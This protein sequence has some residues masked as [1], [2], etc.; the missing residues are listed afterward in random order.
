[1]QSQ[2]DTVVQYLAGLPADRRD[3]ID[4]GRGVT[5]EY[6]A[7]APQKKHMADYLPGCLG[8]AKF[9]ESGKKRDDLPLD[10]IGTPA[11]HMPADELTALYERSRARRKLT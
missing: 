11:A 7:L 5:L 2:V 6:V 10:G 3:A 8:D 4:V 9:A 1:L